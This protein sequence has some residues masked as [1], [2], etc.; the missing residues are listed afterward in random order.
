MDFPAFQRWAE[1][2]PV[3]HEITQPIFDR[4]LRLFLQATALSYTINT[5]TGLV[6]QAEGLRLHPRTAPEQE[7]ALA[8]LARLDHPAF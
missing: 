2:N 6:T 7:M 4:Q 5:E 1:R 8:S 3:A